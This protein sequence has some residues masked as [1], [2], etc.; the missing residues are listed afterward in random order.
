MSATP[1]SDILQKRPLLNDAYC[2]LKKKSA[3]W[4]NIG[5]AFAVPYDYR[6]GLRN[7]QSLSNEDR[8]EKVIYKWQEISYHTQVTWDEFIKVLQS[9]S[10][11]FKDTAQEV[12]S[13][14]E[15]NNKQFSRCGPLN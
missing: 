6:E 10:L 13:F 5:R 14:L 3:K 2:L 1:T 12:L 9:D 8:L 15:K 11:N 7:D 4:S